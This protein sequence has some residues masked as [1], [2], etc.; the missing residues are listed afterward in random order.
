V[1]S[2][3]DM[4]AWDAAVGGWVPTDP[5]YISPDG[6]HYVAPIRAATVDIVDARTG[7]TL[8]RIP[9]Q[10]SHINTVIGYTQTAVYL[11]TRDKAS[12][13]GLW[14]IETSSWKL[15]RVS[16]EQV[17]WE[18]VDEAAAWGIYTT[19]ESSSSVKRLDL[20]TGVVTQ[21][22]PASQ[23]SLEVAGFVGSGVLVVSPLG[24]VLAARVINADGSSQA[25]QVPAGLNGA[26]LSPWVFQDGKAILLAFSV[27]LV[28]YVPARG[29]QV[30]VPTPD[31]Y[32]V[33]GHCTAA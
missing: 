4:T 30:V 17:D 9:T 16:S 8:S 1:S 23:D 22:G 28:A 25:V 19:P 13:P 20:S 32:R 2:Y 21:V 10:N 5:Q 31:L 14:R 11:V 33:L 7:V 3:N 26:A 27:G 15:S 12:P 29:F 6:T 18:V 24:L